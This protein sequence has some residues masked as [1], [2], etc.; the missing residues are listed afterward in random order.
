MDIDKVIDG[1]IKL[2]DKKDE[3]RRRHQEEL[4][5]INEQM[6]KI[7]GYLHKKLQELGLDQFKAKG[8]GTVFLKMDVSVTVDDRE[9]FFKF[10]RDHAQWD[11]LDTR[12]SKTVVADYVDEHGEPPP[13]VRFVQEE[14][15]QVR[16]G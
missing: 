11:L 9:E 13:G 12:C 4:A 7:E 10:V 5:P 16:R 8:V 1:Y 6:Q 3:T 15:V 2:R 14:V